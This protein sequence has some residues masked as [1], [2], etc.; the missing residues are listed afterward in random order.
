MQGGMS[1]CEEETAFPEMTLG[2]AVQ[3]GNRTDK[4]RA[5]SLTDGM[6]DVH[7]RYTIKV[8]VSVQPCVLSWLPIR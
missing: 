8:G 3:P 2:R 4:K 6:L 1:T 5:A 7:D